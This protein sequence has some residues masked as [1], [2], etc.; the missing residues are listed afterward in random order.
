MSIINAVEIT[1]LFSLVNMLSLLGIGPFAEVAVY[2]T[3]CV[4]LLLGMPTD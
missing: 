3:Y 1:T 4:L 2:L